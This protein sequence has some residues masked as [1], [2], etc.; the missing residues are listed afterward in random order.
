MCH[1]I[2]FARAGVLLFALAGCSLTETTTTVRVQAGP[3]TERIRLVRPYA[4]PLS[5]TWTQEGTTVVGQL[6]FTNA[7]QLESVQFNHRT[8]ATE[9]KPNKRYAT[10]A[11]IFG[12]ML[13]VAGVAL[14][15]NA[16]GKSDVVTCGN[17]SSAPRDGDKCSSEAGAWRELGAVT[18]GAGVGAILGGVIVQSRKHEV[19]TKELPSDEQV[20]VIPDR[21][22][23]GRVELLEGAVVSASLSSGGMWS[24]S[25]DA[26]GVVRIALAGA[27]VTEP[28][29]ATFKLESTRHDASGLQLASTP[30]GELEL[31]P[32]NAHVRRGREARGSV[33]VAR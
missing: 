13:S 17:G 28:A 9:T 5:A 31:E 27:S 20:R 10:A 26:T 25:V 7:C 3:A 18:L 4:A 29:R 6:A 19:E 1:A 24:G 22:R 21:D 33:A 30:L 12:S 14:I 16:Q 8:Q 32:P 15:A 2:R 23:C 11:Y